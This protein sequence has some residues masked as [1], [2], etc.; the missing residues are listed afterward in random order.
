MFQVY[1]KVIQLYMYTYIIFQIIF[2]SRL[3]QDTDYT[4][5]CYAVNI[6]CLW[7]IY[8]LKLEIWHCIHTKSNKWNQ[9]VINFLGKNSYVF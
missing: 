5:L 8:F 1:S 4:S 6:C 9:S 2:H 7:H 3:L